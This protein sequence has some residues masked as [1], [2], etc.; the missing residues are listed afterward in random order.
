MRLDVTAVGAL[1]VDVVVDAAVGGIAPTPD[2]PTARDS[3]ESVDA[4]GMARLLRSV[5]SLPRSVRLGGSAYNALVRLAHTR[6]DLALGFTGVAGA[7]PFGARS[8]SHELRALGVDTAGIAAVPG[9]AGVCLA[10]EDGDARRLHVHPGANLRMAA[11]LRDSFDAI[12]GRLARSRFVHVTSFLDDTTPAELHRVLREVRRRSPAA[13][14]CL[15]P[16]DEWCARPS[17]DVAALVG[18][19]DYVLVNEREFAGIAD[20]ARGPVVVKCPDGA[21]IWLRG[22]RRARIAHARL[23]AGDIRNPTGA[24][25]AFAAGLLAGLLTPPQDASPSEAFARAVDGG[26]DEAALG[27]G[28]RLGLQFAREH[29]LGAESRPGS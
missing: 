28:V 9:Q 29:L 18:V 16:G 3:E 15:D 5:E 2:D 1:N 25:D 8:H 21:D 10:I 14:I 20:L 22:T 23:A 13:V 17:A 24:G 27:R 12:V 6:P 26:R 7:P 11:H 19:A 4:A